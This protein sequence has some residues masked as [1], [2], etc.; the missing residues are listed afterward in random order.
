MRSFLTP[1]IGSVTRTVLLAPCL[2]ICLACATPF[3]FDHLEKGMT[4]REV[5]ALVGEPKSTWVPDI[6]GQPPKPG[7]VEEAWD[8]PPSRHRDERYP[9]PLRHRAS[10][11]G[12]HRPGRGRR[13]F[14]SIWIPMGPRFTYIVSM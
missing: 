11:V 5:R 4:Q 1:L 9:R 10:D 14:G 13:T 8:V 3:P 6:A 2:L 12:Y 7:V